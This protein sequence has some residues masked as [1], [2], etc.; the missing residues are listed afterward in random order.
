M[1]LDDL[2]T[3]LDNGAKIN[4]KINKELTKCSKSY[5]NMTEKNLLEVSQEKL[6]LMFA[7]KLDKGRF[8]ELI[9]NQSEVL[10]AQINIDLKE[11]KKL[12]S[13]INSWY[14]N[15][16]NLLVEYGDYLDKSKLL[17]DTATYFKKKTR[18]IQCKILKQVKHPTET[19]EK[20]KKMTRKPMVIMLIFIRHSNF[21]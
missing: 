2:E 21:L 3:I 9:D 11:L 6:L 18:L 15:S 17:S 5:T 12:V 19:K 10:S 16:N 20:M 1:M 14:D 8:G 7:D 4:T 13:I